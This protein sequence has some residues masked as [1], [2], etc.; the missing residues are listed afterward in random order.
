MF[1]FFS[2]LHILPYTIFFEL[3]SGLSYSCQFITEQ[4]SQVDLINA[5]NSAFLTI[6]IFP[7]LSNEGLTEIDDFGSNI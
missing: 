5:H 1:P 4:G 7:P 3:E 2:S 6:A